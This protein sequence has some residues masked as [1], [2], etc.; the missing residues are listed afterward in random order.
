[1][2]KFFVLRVQYN[3]LGAINYKTNPIWKQ[4]IDLKSKTDNK[5]GEV[6]FPQYKNQMIVNTA[7][8]WWL[9]SPIQRLEALHQKYK[10]IRT[11]IGFP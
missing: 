8:K 11:R 9:Y 7:S 2:P 4:T 1:M 10:D 6:D 5:G 3:S